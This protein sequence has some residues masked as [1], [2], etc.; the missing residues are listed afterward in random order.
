MKTKVLKIYAVKSW[1][2]EY[3]ADDMVNSGHSYKSYDT[4]LITATSAKIAISA[5][6]KLLG[7]HYVEKRATCLGIA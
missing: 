5:V 4:H 7:D 1:T 6:I 3:K 2:W